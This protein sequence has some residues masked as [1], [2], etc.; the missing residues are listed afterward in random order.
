MVASINKV[1][2][3][4]RL[5][6]DPEVNF[7]QENKKIVNISLAT[8]DTWKNKAGERQEKT[9]WHRIV[10]F[11]Q[12]IAGIA[13][14]YLKKGALIYIEGSLQTRKWTDNGGQERYST[15]VI[16]SAFNGELKIIDFNND[17]SEEEAA[18]RTPR[19]RGQD[20]IER[21]EAATDRAFAERKAKSKKPNPEPP[22]DFNDEIPF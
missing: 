19:N 16:L 15:E 10:I 8:S 22:E 21:G 6:K 2:L 9:E 14:N 7:T 13:S 4:G 12:G 3:L 20:A 5:G 18:Y 11:N 1:C 17:S